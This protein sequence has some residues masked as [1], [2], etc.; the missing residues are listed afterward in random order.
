[1][2][3]DFGLKDAVASEASGGGQYSSVVL[4]DD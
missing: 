3:M 4:G 2:T 1:M